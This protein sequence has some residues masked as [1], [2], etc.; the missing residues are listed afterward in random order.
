MDE[1]SAGIR[2]GPSI[3][4]K[5]M[6]QPKAP[7]FIQKY[8]TTPKAKKRRRI[9]AQSVLRE[10][11][12]REY[13]RRR[14]QFLQDHPWCSVCVKERPEAPP[15]RAT[16]VHHKLGRRGARLLDIRHWLATCPGCHDNIHRIDPERPDATGPKWAKERGYLGSFHQ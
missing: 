3:V 13:S 7:W 1:D 2:S 12:Q 14:K 11:E 15:G 5:L 16:E 9:R 8:G 6:P 10:A 4:Q